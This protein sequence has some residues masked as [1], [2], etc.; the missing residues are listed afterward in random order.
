MC[1]Q[2]IYSIKNFIKRAKSKIAAEDK[3]REIYDESVV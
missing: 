1:I 3:I 2:M